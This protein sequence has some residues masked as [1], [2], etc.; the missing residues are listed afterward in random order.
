MITFKLYLES[1]NNPYSFQKTG[2][3]NNEHS[4]HFATDKGNNYSVHF[5]HHDHD[6]SK[7][8]MH[9]K[10][11]EGRMGVT[12][13]ERGGAAKV[14]STVKHITQHHLQTNRGI[15]HVEMFSHTEDR[16]RSKVYNK[17]IQKHAPAS[18]HTSPTSAH[19][20]YDTF[21]IHKHKDTPFR[22]LAAKAKDTFHSINDRLH[23]Y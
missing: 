19:D 1:M 14:F 12:G 23:G 4:Y 9:F 20:N 21:T 8:T 5:Q 7:A 15:K 16:A 6:P 10:D 2:V 13:G 18:T 17:L 22:R 11:Q 3:E